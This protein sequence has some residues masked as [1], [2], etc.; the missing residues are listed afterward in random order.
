MNHPPVPLLSPRDL[1]AAK[2]FIEAQDLTFEP[3]F[4]EILGVFDN[5]RLVATGARA[6]FV[7]KMFAIDSEYQGSE[8]LGSLITELIRM[9]QR[10]GHEDFFVFTRPEHAVSFEQYNFRL[11]VT[12]GLVSLL[13]YGGGIETYLRAHAG[14]VRPGHNGAIVLNGNPLTRGHLYLIEQSAALVDHLYLFVVT[15]DRSVFPYVVRRR[16][17]E[18]ATR[19]LPNV[20]PLETSRYAISAGT[21]PSYFLK[22]VDAV[23]LAQMQIDLHLFAA[24]LAPAFFVETR[25]VGHEP[26]CALTAAYNRAMAEILPGYGIK[27]VEITRTRAGDEYI[28]ATRVRAA[29]LRRDWDALAPLVPPV[30]LD[31]LKSPEGTTLSAQLARQAEPGTR[32]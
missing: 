16:L 31:F 28:S 9:G 22:R 13:E 6:G 3:S 10:V 19:H 27:L 26:F 23:A 1:T 17:V 30:T 15:E 32:T 29:F 5:G 24:K 8:I 18:E 14:L 7:L 12:H 25:F 11:L 4:D 20:L 2:R 21:F